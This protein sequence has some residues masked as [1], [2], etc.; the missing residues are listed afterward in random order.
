MIKILISTAT[1]PPPPPRIPRGTHLSDIPLSK[2]KTPS[3]PFQ[4][5]FKMFYTLRP[6]KITFVNQG[7]TLS[8]VKKNLWNLS[9]IPLSKQ[10]TPS[11]P[12]QAI[13]KMFYTLPPKKNHLRKSGS[14]SIASQKKLVE[15]V[16]HF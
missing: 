13:F 16:K 6:K 2:R 15:P 4:A 9:N 14:N 10:K 8:L 12:F 1:P 7:A 11:T 3:T 5:I